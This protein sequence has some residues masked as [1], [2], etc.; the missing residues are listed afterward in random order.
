MI[1]SPYVLLIFLFV[2]GTVSSA[3]YYITFFCKVF[4]NATFTRSGEVSYSIQP[5]GFTHWW[6]I[7]V[8]F[9]LTITGPHRPWDSWW[10][11]EEG[12]YK[13]KHAGSSA[14]LTVGLHSGNMSLWTSEEKEKKEK[15]EEEQYSTY[16]TYSTVQYKN[17][18]GNR[19]RRSK[20]R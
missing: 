2:D 9:S 5:T 3:I 20:K 14:H 11:W 16:S 1:I 8:A 7:G 19:R 10:D 12:D 13:G 17:T 15:E 18:P 6:W 4:S